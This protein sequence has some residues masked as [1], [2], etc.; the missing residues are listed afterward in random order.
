MTKLSKQ[1][2]G[3][4]IRKVNEDKVLEVIG[5]Y[6]T[7]NFLI[8]IGDA[9]YVISVRNGKI[10][11]LTDEIPKLY[12]WQFALR[13]SIESWAKFT[14]E[15]PAPMYNDIWAMARHQKLRIEG[16]TKLMW[17]NLRALSWM[18]DLMRQV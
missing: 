4:W 12:D 9:G 6:F 16:D 10:E 2:I 15:I 7:A 11:E 14:Q 13:A 3:E 8:E 17:Q 5:G 18:L 1:W